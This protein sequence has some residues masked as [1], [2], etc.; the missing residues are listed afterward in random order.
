MYLINS[1]VVFS[2]ILVVIFERLTN[3]PHSLH[4]YSVY[5]VYYSVFEHGA[6]YTV[7]M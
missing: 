4:P 7:I 6:T 3:Y 2:V 5:K 1:G